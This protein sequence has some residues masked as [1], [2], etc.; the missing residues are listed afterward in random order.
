MKIACWCEMSEV[1][2]HTGSRW[3]AVTQITT[4]SAT[5]S[6]HTTCEDGIQQQMTTP[7]ANSVSPRAGKWG[8][9]PKQCLCSVHSDGRVRICVNNI[10]MGFIGLKMNVLWLIKHFN[11]FILISSKYWNI[12]ASYRYWQMEV[13]C[14]SAISLRICW[15]LC[16]YKHVIK[17]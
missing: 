2:G 16:C 11:R 15:Y 5:I 13:L 8:Y 14:T 12:N 10:K 1:N 9:I 3:E 7:G 4:H 6:E 17:L